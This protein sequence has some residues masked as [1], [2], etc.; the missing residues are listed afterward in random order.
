MQSTSTFVILHLI[1][2]PLVL[3]WLLYVS[4]QRT[5]ISGGKILI[6]GIKILICWRHCPLNP[7]QIK[8]VLLVVKLSGTPKVWL[9]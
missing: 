6:S 4:I 5:C 2:K 7:R 1:T 3:F 8:C 9:C